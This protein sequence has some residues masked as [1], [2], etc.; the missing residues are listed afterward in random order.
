MEAQRA[1]RLEEELQQPRQHLATLEAATLSKPQARRL[2]SDSQEHVES[3]RAIPITH[4][5]KALPLETGI[6]AKRRPETTEGKGP[7]SQVAEDRVGTGPTGAPSDVA[8]SSPVASAR[9]VLA[10]AGGGVA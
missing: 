3:D 6:T 4:E 2:R 5:A 10:A 1:T 9:E 8:G 7:T